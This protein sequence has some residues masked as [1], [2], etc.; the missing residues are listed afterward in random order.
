MPKRTYQ[1][2][3]RKR[4]KKHGLREDGFTEPVPT[5]GRSVFAARTPEAET[6]SDLDDSGRADD[7]LDEPQP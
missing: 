1:P 4:A 2:N 5:V 6:D 7:K 3:N